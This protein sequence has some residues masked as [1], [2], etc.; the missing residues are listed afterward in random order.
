MRIISVAAMFALLMLPHSAYAKDR[1]ASEVEKP[2]V[3]TEKVY[4]AE[5]SASM[6]RAARTKAEAQE[7]VWDRKMKILM[8]GICTG[9]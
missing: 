6:G 2:K 9:C 7:G 3:S 8:K 5:E 4:S 1:P